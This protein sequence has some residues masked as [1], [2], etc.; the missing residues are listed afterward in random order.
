MSTLNDFEQLLNDASS[1][2]TSKERELIHTDQLLA[3]EE[4]T[5]V[6]RKEA[7]D[8]IVKTAN[9]AQQQVSG[10]IAAIVTSAL[11]ITHGTSYEF[12]V[13]FVTRRNSTEA[14]LVLMKKGHVVDPLG[15][16]GLGVANIIAIALRAG[17]IIMENKTEKFMALD[18]PTAALAGW[19]QP[20]AGEMLLGLCQKLGFQILLT[21]HSMPL[22]ECADRA[23]F[24]SM[25]SS[26]IASARLIE[27]KEEIRVLMG[28]E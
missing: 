5:L 16:S 8:I 19:R 6:I 14:D 7:L 28:T 18:E 2:V 17:F 25:D 21:T 3:A 23:Y 15:N 26:D 24:I 11:H 13:K 4:G 10:I 1:Q 20:L 22:A 12:D 27:N 9:K